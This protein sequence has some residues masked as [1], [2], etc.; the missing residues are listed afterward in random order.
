[1]GF[2]LL[3]NAK[4]E[5][6]MNDQANAIELATDLTIAWL[7]NPNSRMSAADVPEF[8]ERM[9]SALGKLTENAPSAPDDVGQKYVPAVSV[10]DSLASRDHTISLIDGKPYRTL[11]RHLA[12]HGLTA[13]EYRARYQ[14]KPDYPMVSPAYSE[15][16]CA[17]AKKN[18]LG[19]RIKRP[20][21]AGAAELRKAATKGKNEPSIKTKKN[22]KKQG[23]NR[24]GV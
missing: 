6:L 23:E 5:T 21:D 15:N 16:R 17:L 13:E 1:M 20:V 9:H 8:L 10:R 4:W 22:A 18:G 2:G 11:R 3:P 19:G 24:S 7:R 14:L 12:G